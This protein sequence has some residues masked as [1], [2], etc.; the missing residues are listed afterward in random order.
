[1]AQDR[2]AGGPTANS[3]HAPQS[4]TPSGRCF[5]QEGFKIF[6]RAVGC[7]GSGLSAMAIPVPSYSLLSAVTACTHP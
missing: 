5:A 4:E 7:A 1:M 6:W 2:A 3:P